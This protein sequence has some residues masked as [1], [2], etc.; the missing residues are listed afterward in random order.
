MALSSNC[1]IYR[2][3][4]TLRSVVKGLV[5]NAK[6]L[7]AKNRPRPTTTDPLKKKKLKKKKKKKKK[8]RSRRNNAETSAKRK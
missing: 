4:A 2:H 5:S 3:L 6:N 1:P 7:A 8:T